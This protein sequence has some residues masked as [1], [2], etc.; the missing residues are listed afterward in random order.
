MSVCPSL[1]DLCDLSISTI[2]IGKTRNGKWLFSS[3][4]D[5]SQ[6]CTVQF[7]PLTHSHSASMC[8]TFSIKHHSHTDSTGVPGSVWI[9]ELAQ[10]HFR[11]RDGK[12]WD[13]TADPLDGGRPHYCVFCVPTRARKKDHIFPVWASL[14]WFPSLESWSFPWR[15]S[16]QN[17]EV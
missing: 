7:L 1:G 10:G 12:D 11:T 15:T 17:C 8:S 2:I 13:R 5:H 3:L 9:S 4:D 14:P 6:L 16:Y